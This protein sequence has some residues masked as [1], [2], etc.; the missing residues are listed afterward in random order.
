MK[1]ILPIRSLVLLI[2]FSLF[3]PNK[4]ISQDNFVGTKI[5]KNDGKVSVQTIPKENTS[6][7]ESL[8]DHLNGLHPT[9]VGDQYVLGGSVLW[10]TDDQGTAAI[11]NTTVINGP[12]NRGVTGWGLNQMRA[13]VYS[14]VNNI[15][16]WELST[17]PYDPHVD[18]SDY[19]SFIAIAAGP[20]FYIYDTT[21][22]QLLNYIL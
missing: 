7:I 20:N 6:G 9:N 17:L 3:L 8:S 4:I 18:I 2:I 13:S 1:S 19:S 10:W 5:L 12:G 11:A 21:G 22:T 16:L 14:D 15:P